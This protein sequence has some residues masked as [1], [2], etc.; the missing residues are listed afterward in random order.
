MACLSFCGLSGCLGNACAGAEARCDGTG[1]RATAQANIGPISASAR[2]GI[3][4]DG[5]LDI[6]V[7]F[8]PQ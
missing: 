1:C 5:S 7:C 3:N 8:I 2:M 6:C 4:E